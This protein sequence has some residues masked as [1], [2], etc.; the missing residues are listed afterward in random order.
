VERSL[1]RK[2]A[3]GATGLVVLGGGGAAYAVTKSN[4]NERQAFLG[5]VAKR[6]NVTPEKLNSA[7]K[8][9]FEDRL[10]AAVKAGRLTQKQADE[11]KKKVEQGGVPPMLGP[12][13][14]AGAGAGAARGHF[15]FKGGPGRAGGPIHNGIDAAAKYIGLSDKQLMQK[16]QS[17]KSL[18]DIAGEQKK[19]VAGL[20]SAITDSV[21]SDLDKAVKD[22]HLTQAQEDH[23]LKRLGDKL[24]ALVNAKG[25]PGPPPGFRH[26]HGAWGAQKGGAPRNGSF[27]PPPGAPAP[28]PGAPII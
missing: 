1:K 7:L 15:F 22:K 28:P 13:F 5:D 21:K 17:G 24:D 6:L 18:A 14:G 12:G 11:I 26:G 10:D 9:A 27:A 23:I 19:S 20:K 3:I 16:L 2:L 8:G 4:D 25:F